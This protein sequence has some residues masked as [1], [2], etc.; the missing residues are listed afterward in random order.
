MQQFGRS[1]SEHLSLK[2]TLTSHIRELKAQQT[3]TESACKSILLASWV[4]AHSTPDLQNDQHQVSPTVV[5]VQNVLVAYWARK[6]IRYALDSS[7]ASLPPS[8]SKPSP[9]LRSD[10]TA[11]NASRLSSHCAS[12]R[13][14]ALESSSSSGKVRQDE[15]RRSRIPSAFTSS[16][17]E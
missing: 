1:K 10:I 12:S 9:A 5:L 7:S 17:S 16:V 15:S 11:S 14:D 4:P 8:S 6:M 3:N 13:P 2:P